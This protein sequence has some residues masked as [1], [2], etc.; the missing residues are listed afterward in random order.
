MRELMDLGTVVLAIR[1]SN[2][3]IVVAEHLL[4]LTWDRA[5][6]VLITTGAVEFVS[7]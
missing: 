3:A 6:K 7:P 2:W 5:A 4:P 1:V